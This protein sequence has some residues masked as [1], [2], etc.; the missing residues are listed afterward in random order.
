MSV[1]AKVTVTLEQPVHAGTG[2]LP[3]YRHP[4]HHHIPGSVL[5]GACAAAWIRALGTPEPGTAH[6]QPFIEAFESDGGFGPLHRAG[7]LPVPV[8]VLVHKYQEEQGC[9]RLW[10]DRSLGAQDTECPDCSQ[11]LEAA[12]GEPHERPV[13][14][15]R[16]RAAL[17]TDGVAEDE[18]LYRKDSLD[19]RQVFTGW[20]SAGAVGAFEVGGEPL[21]RLW[22]GGG[23]STGG[24]A[25]VT[26]DPDAQ[27]EELETDGSAVIL[28]LASPAIFVDAAGLPTDVPST[29]ELH[30]TLGVNV[31]SVVHWMRWGEA[32][33]WHAAAGL[34]KPTER[35]VAA[36]STYRV[37]CDRPP[38][39]QAL[40]A[41]RVRGVGLRRR[42]GFGALCPPLEPPRP[43]GYYADVVRPLR[44]LRLV[45][46]L[47]DRLRARRAVLDSGAAD[48]PFLLQ[49]PGKLPAEAGAA[50]RL[51]LG[52]R[53]PGEY[54][55][56]LDHL[57]PA[58]QLVSVTP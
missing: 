6:R 26:V 24:L 22:L 8:S 29:A 27:P 21:R 48:D 12:K 55:Q 56:V 31:L 50:L 28:R 16:T 20:I 40:R 41:L 9:Q 33:G 49:L 23:R 54:E 36:G 44:E 2:P 30:R 53:Y 39:S 13:R 47:V 42:E 10:W 7:S 45:A 18:K 3:D 57:D 11:N 32:A 58:Q 25:R 51:V 43:W 46:Q 52:I 17:S 35:V 38:S 34:A 14:L 15:Q 19:R 5:R 4:T 1:T 37:Q